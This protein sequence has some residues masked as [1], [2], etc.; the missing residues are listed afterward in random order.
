MTGP[1][2]A[3]RVMLLNDELPTTVL[4]N[5][6]VNGVEVRRPTVLGCTTVA[7]LLSEAAYGAANEMLDKHTRANAWGKV[8]MYAILRGQTPFANSHKC[9]L[10]ISSASLPIHNAVVQKG[11]CGK[12]QNIAVTY[13]LV[14]LRTRQL[15][16]SLP[17]TADALTSI[18]VPCRDVA[19]TM[20]FTENKYSRSLVN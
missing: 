19:V 11:C 3:K 5:D 15:S 13:S 2:E 14:H 16:A 20:L 4:G 10:R 17:R 9:T 12:A 1:F 6:S 7:E 8:R 18:S